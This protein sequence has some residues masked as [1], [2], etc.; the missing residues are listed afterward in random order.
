M[1]YLLKDKI[2][3]LIRFIKWIFL[4]TLVGT[5]VGFLTALFLNLLNITTKLIS[6]FNYYFIFL[7]LVLFINSLFLFKFF[8][9]DDVHSTD[10]VIEIINNRGDISF[11]SILKAFFLPI[12]TISWGGSLGKEAPCAD[13]GAGIGSFISKIF[14]LNDN[15]RKK[16][17]ICGLSA[18]F[19]SV[20][21]T[22]IAGSIFGIEILYMDRILYDVL[23]TSFISSFVSYNITKIFGVKYFNY[24]INLVNFSFISFYEIILAGIFFGLCSLF[25]I[26]VLNINKKICKIIKIQEPF[27]GFIGGGFLIIF[28]ILFSSDYLGLG[29]N[30]IESSLNGKILPWYSFIIKSF[31]TG[32]TFNF[33]GSGGLITPIFF[34]GAASGNLFAKLLNLD[35]AFFSKLGLVGL[36]SG[37]VNT[38]ISAS[39]L[40]IE[41][42]GHNIAP[43][44]VLVSLISF[45]VSGYQT[46]YPSQRLT[47]KKLI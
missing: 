44:A 30:F 38:P 26:W 46:I 40:A 34:V 7:P 17:M 22:P 8:I 37:A 45:F 10:K 2:F 3:F 42:F 41:L 39:I 36:L 6:S 21:G 32:I 23:L 35:I 28:S 24:I 13:V 43:Y 33:G 14:K 11:I 47:F 9:K 27:K 29:L 31:T 16:L 20:F 4:A 19:A 1:R 15:D 5:F 18:G 12:W 25:F